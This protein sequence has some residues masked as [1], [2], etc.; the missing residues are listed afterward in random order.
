LIPILP[1]L[2]I[3]G[4]VALA[5]TIERVQSLTV[6]KA[7]VGA[8]TLV[9]VGSLTIAGWEFAV[10]SIG[11]MRDY[12]HFGLEIEQLAEEPVYRFINDQ[13][14]TDARVMMINTNHGFF[15][16]RDFVADS[17]FEAS[18]IAALMQEA[19][20]KS[21][22]STILRDLHVS[23][24]LIKKGEGGVPYPDSLLDFL[25]DPQLVRSVYRSPDERFDVAQVLVMAGSG[26]ATTDR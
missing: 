19:E 3:A 17:F 7:A 8:C 2:A 12:L 26:A 13:L 11:M 22:I 16:R 6:R 23:H 18:Q 1:L 21:D 4:A 15:C 9:L 20:S 24:L 5:D 25:N 14:P 10:R